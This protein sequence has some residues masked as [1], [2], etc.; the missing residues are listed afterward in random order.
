MQNRSSEIDVKLL[1]FAI[2]RTTN[3][4][5]LI[6]KRFSGITLA[7]AGEGSNTGGP[8]VSRNDE[9]ATNPFLES[10]DATNPSADDIVR[11]RELEIKVNQTPTNFSKSSSRKY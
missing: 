7:P 6:A 4:E 11:E 10:P 3:F 2:Q 1:L 5:S 9:D 8:K